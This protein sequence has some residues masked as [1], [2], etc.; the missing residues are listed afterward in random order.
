MKFRNLKD[1]IKEKKAKSKVFEDSYNEAVENAKEFKLT[2]RGRVTLAEP[3][4]KVR[5]HVKSKE[6]DKLSILSIGILIGLAISAIA[7]A[8]YADGL[9]RSM[10]MLN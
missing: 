8:S 10:G 3:N 2:S 9:S 7:F 5:L 1:I 6:E 4:P